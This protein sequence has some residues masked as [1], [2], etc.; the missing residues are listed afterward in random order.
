MLDDAKKLIEKCPSLNLS[1]EE[2]MIAFSHS[3][4]LH[5]KEMEEIDRYTKLT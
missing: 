4:E 3:K 5:I 1:I 2:I